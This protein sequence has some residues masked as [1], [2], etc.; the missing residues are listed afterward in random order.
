[1]VCQPHLSGFSIKIK[2]SGDFSASPIK[3]HN[4]T[5]RG[6]ATHPN[7]V[8]NRCWKCEGL[9]AGNRVLTVK[10]WS[11]HQGYSVGV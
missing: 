7:V 4:F 5:T 8:R 10:A 11:C 6:Q 3:Q 2:H 9:I 1:M